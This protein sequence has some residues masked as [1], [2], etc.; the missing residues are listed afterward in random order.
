MEPAHAAIEEII[1]QGSSCCGG[2]QT[3]QYGRFLRIWEQYRQLR[4]QDPSLTRP[5]RWSRRAPARPFDIAEP[6][7]PAEPLPVP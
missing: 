2:W 6:Q 7:L 3:A 1:E 4:E 5:D